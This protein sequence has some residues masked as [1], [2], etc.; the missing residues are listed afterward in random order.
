[1]CVI[2]ACAKL[3]GLE[4]P[5]VDEGPPKPN[6]TPFPINAVGAEVSP[7]KLKVTTGCKVEDKSQYLTIDNKSDKPI[8]YD[9]TSPNT[10]AVGLLESDDGPVAMT[11]KGVLAPKKYKILHL[12]VLSPTAATAQAEIQV[13][14]G[15]VLQR[16]PV[17][18]QVTGGSLLFAP[19]VV[20]FGQVKAGT[21]PPDQTL[22]IQNTGTDTVTIASWTGATTADFVVGGGSGTLTI[23]AGEKATAPISFAPGNPG[24]QIST[25]LTPNT[26][27]PLCTDAP[28]V[29]V[30]GQRVNLKVT[31]G[32]GSLDLK[33][34]GC[35]A[36]AAANEKDIEVLNFS[37]QNADL[38]L[39][40]V[41]GGPSHFVVP[42][43]ATAP[44]A[45]DDQNPGRVLIPVRLATP[46]G[47]VPGRPITESIQVNVTKPEVSSAIVNATFQIVG[48]VLDVTPT[49]LTFT[50]NGTNTF[51]IT[52]SGNNSAFLKNTSNNNL[53]TFEDGTDSVAVNPPGFFGG[54]SAMVRLKLNATTGSSTAEIKSSLDTSI[55]ILSGPVCNAVP[56]VS[57]SANLP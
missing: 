54:N 3:A 44:P 37:T 38:E 17:D 25:V 18:I 34:V 2:A 6:G 1:V 42:T 29:A 23:R 43:T 22:E 48:A 39:R 20:D 57:C 26:Q 11:V 24:A 7:T 13:R 36:P 33:T 51:R 55:P 10:A 28:S 12:H 14:T 8:D 16:I 40:M 45:I 32:P 35:G 53:Y 50:A 9:V 41:Q 19:T 15:D 5:Y 56:V 21:T 31:V 46:V 52:N 4:S 49:A 27:V 30:K 47:A